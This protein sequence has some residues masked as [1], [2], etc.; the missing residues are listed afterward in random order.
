MV[1][2]SQVHF[3]LFKHE[4]EKMLEY[5]NKNNLWILCVVL[6]ENRPDHVSFMWDTA[7]L[8]KECSDDDLPF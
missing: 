7:L 1:K 5:M 3:R 8:Q 2:V 4:L 6:E